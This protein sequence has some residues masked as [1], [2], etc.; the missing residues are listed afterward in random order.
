VGGDAGQ[1]LVI[2]A[3]PDLVAA[4]PS[5]SVQTAVVELVGNDPHDDPFGNGVADAWR[6][7]QLSGI[8]DNCSYPDWRIIR[9]R[10]ICTLPFP[11]QRQIRL[12]RIRDNYSPS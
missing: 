8:P 9:S 3:V 11:A 12:E 1:E 7:Q 4:D 5:Q 10:A 6:E 2:G